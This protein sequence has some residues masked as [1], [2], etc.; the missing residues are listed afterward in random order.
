[1]MDQP[2]LGSR[3]RQHQD[4]DRGALDRERKR[5]RVEA[6]RRMHG[7]R[8]TQHVKNGI[9]KRIKKGFNR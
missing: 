8:R 7:D 3:I 2:E 1:M 5:L 9:I 4:V 6:E